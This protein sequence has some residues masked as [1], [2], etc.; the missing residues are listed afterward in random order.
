MCHFQSL[1]GGPSSNFC[2]SE[3][4]LIECT[5]RVQ[6]PVLISALSE[7]LEEASSNTAIVHIKSLCTQDYMQTLPTNVPSFVGQ[8]NNISCYFGKL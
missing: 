5:A 8:A 7:T 3:L 4:N 1:H 6:M 2:Y